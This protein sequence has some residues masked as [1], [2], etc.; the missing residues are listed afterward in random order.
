MCCGNDPQHQKF[1]AILSGPYVSAGSHSITP[2]N[3][4]KAMI[5]HS[6]R[7]LPKVTWQNDRDQFM[8]PS[9]KPSVEFTRDCV[10]WSLFSGSNETVALRDV[11]Y[12]GQTFQIPNHFF[13]LTR[14]CLRSWKIADS[15]IELDLRAAQEDRFVARW[16]NEHKLSSASQDV[17]DAGRNI[18]QFFYEH[19]PQLDTTK[20]KIAT[21]DAGWWQ[22]RSALTDRDLGTDLFQPLKEA[23]GVLKAKLLPQISASGFITCAE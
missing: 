15:D 5:V 23:H 11:I 13:P 12:L 6:V 8:Q 19:L 7:R 3:F 16:L 9:S 21:W 17:L 18:F 14:A 4:E 20:F 22:V 1:T 2:D 10:V